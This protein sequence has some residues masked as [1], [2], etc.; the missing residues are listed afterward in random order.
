MEKGG[1]SFVPC[2]AL[3]DG[4]GW[5]WAVVSYFS[6]VTKVLEICGAIKKKWLKFVQCGLS[7]EI[8]SRL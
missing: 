2:L 8:S 3:P 5:Q 1:A 7:N 6:L 4:Q